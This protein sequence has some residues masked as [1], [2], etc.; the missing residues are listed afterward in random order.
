MLQRFLPFRRL[1]LE[2]ICMS[3]DQINA[4][5]YGV[6]TGKMGMAVARASFEVVMKWN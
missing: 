2:V 6:A 3:N 1:Q 5:L 4:S